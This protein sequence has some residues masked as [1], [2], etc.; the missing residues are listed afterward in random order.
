MSTS[1]EFDE[2]LFK[3]MFSYVYMLYVI[4]T[5]YML[6]VHV[7]CYMYMLVICT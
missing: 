6:Y 4:C 3:I 7:I 5:C 1:G 2:D